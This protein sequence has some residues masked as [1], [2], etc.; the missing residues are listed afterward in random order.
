MLPLQSFQILIIL[1]GFFW[2]IESVIAEFFFE[3]P[4][5]TYQCMEAVFKWDSGGTPPY[6]AVLL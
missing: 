3:W 4:N 1:A 6:T 5:T 2:G